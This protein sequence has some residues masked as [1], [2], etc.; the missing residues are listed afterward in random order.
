[1]YYSINHERL[2]SNVFD[3]HLGVPCIWGYIHCIHYSGVMNGDISWFWGRGC[4]FFLILVSILEIFPYSEIVIGVFSWFWGR[5]CR[6]FLI[7]GVE[8]VDY[9]WFWGRD[10][11][12]FMILG[13][14]LDIFPDSGVEIG[15]F[16]WFW[17]GDWRFSCIWG[18]I[19]VIKG[20]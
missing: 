11:R 2:K 4:R 13:S 19:G 20:W 17:D 12:F 3:L 7:L 6:L 9:S 1:M 15:D 18:Y 5:D 14:W 10:W 16:S 8:I